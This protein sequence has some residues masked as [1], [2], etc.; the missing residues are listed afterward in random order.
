MMR[1]LEVLEDV[2]AFVDGVYVPRIG[3]LLAGLNDIGSVEVLR[4]P[5]GTLFGRNASMGA[6][7]IRT[8]RPGKTFGGEATA[9]LG[10]Y[11]RQRLSASVDLPVSDTLQTRFSALAYKGDGFDRNDLTGKRI[12]RNDGVSVR[13]SVHYEVTPN[14]TWDLK[15]DYANLSGDGYNTVTVVSKTVTPASLATWLARLDPDG[16]GPGMGVLPYTSDTLSR[17]VRQSTDGDLIDI[18]PVPGLSRRHPA[19]APA[20][21]DE[22]RQP[23]P[24]PGAA[25]AIARDAAAAPGSGS[26]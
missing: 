3:S 17:H 1:V 5:Q 11:G 16:A 7:L 12:G 22:R 13:G 15:G 19:G 20:S 2:A 18:G 8:T 14:L 26:D 23:E 21:H 24:L 9:S 10:N 4:G 6:L 25:A